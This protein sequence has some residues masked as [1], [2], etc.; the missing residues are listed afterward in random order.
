VQHKSRAAASETDFMAEGPR[1]AAYHGGTGVIRMRRL[2]ANLP[3]VL[4]L[5]AAFALLLHD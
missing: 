1:A 2:I 5:C 4:T 3:R